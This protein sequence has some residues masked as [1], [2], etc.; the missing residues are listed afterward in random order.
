MFDVMILAV[1]CGTHGFIP[2][3]RPAFEK[4]IELLNL[5]TNYR[6]KKL[7]EKLAIFMHFNTV[8]LLANTNTGK[9][10]GLNRGPK[11]GVKRIK[12]TA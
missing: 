6:H 2:E 12:P 1:V 5:V 3:V 10:S 4:L 11:Y 9:P 8:I 7:T